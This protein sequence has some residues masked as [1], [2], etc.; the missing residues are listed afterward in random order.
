MRKQT[1]A[2]NAAAEVFV[3]VWLKSL[4]KS[5]SLSWWRIYFCFPWTSGRR[6]RTSPTC[7]I[8][9][10]GGV[11]QEWPANAVAGRVTPHFRPT[12]SNC[13]QRFFGYLFQPV[14]NRL[15]NCRRNT[16]EFRQQTVSSVLPN[17][18]DRL[19][20]TRRAIRRNRRCQLAFF[21]AFHSISI[22]MS[23]SLNLIL[24]VC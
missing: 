15:A 1:N 22:L 17:I 9:A 13:P 10:D 18:I 20:I 3:V 16:L 5:M 2:I 6:S 11:V 24:L 12:A 7:P 21:D 14:P 4:S 8:A 23:F 19:R